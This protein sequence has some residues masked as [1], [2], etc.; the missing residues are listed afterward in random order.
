MVENDHLFVDKQQ[1][2]ELVKAGQEAI[3]ADDIDKLRKVHRML[4]SLRIDTGS[5]DDVLATTNI[6]RG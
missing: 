6:V 3:K 2:V 4:E 5:D 1:Y